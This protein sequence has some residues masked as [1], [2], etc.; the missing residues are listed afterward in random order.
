MRTTDTAKENGASTEN[1]SKTNKAFNE[2]SETI[3]DAYKK[4]V[5]MASEFYSNTINSMLEENKKFWNPFEIYNNFFNGNDRLRPGFMA[6]GN[7]GVKNNFGNM[8]L[9]SVQRGFTQMADQNQQMVNTLLKQVEEGSVEWKTINEKYQKRI[10]DAFGATKRLTNAFMD[11]VNAQTEST[12]AASKQMMETFNKELDQM[13]KQNQRFLTDLLSVSQ[14]HQNEKSF[15][16]DGEKN[17]K[18]HENSV[19][20]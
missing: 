4:Q 10:E 13:I 18:K 17:H 3:M 1:S 7:Q 19:N 14:K 15:T 11:T 20:V 16:D 2:A 6:F 9:M 12:I 5:N 8:V